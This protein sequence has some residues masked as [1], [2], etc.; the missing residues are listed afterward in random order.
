MGRLPRKPTGPLKEE[1]PHEEEAG[2]GQ[3]TAPA[4]EEVASPDSRQADLLR[5]APFRAPLP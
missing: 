4:L 1:S 2:P 3:Q 5:R